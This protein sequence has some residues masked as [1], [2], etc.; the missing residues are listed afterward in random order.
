MKLI[1]CRY[2]LLISLMLEIILG[3]LGHYNPE[4]ACL[5][6]VIGFFVPFCFTPWDQDEVDYINKVKR[7]DDK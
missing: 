6:I 7:W 2:A 4:Y 3:F 1:R 5:I